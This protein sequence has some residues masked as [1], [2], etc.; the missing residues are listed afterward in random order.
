ME[1]VERPRREQRIGKE[2][3]RVLIHDGGHG[4]GLPTLNRLRTSSKYGV[5]ESA[6]R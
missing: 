6:S 3:G 2:W 4:V 5:L 1:R